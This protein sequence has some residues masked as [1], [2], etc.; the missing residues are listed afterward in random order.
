[1]G[2]PLFEAAST[3]GRFR[4]GSR[5]EPGPTAHSMTARTYVMRSYLFCHLCERRMWGNT[6]RS[7]RPASGTSSTTARSTRKATAISPGTPATRG[8]SPC[9]KTSCSDPSHGFPGAR[10]RPQPQDPPPRRHPAGP[11]TGQPGPPGTPRRPAS[12]SRRPATAPGQPR[13][14]SQRV[15]ADRQ[16]RP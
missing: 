16:R 15:P 10:L 6:K 2:T 13:A 1:L 3:I 5:P 7:A 9:T 14:R 12:P 8:T 11:R 4:Q